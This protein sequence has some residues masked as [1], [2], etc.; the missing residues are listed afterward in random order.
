MIPPEKWHNSGHDEDECAFS[1]LKDS[2]LFRN[3]HLRSYN[4]EMWV[5]LSTVIMSALTRAYVFSLYSRFPPYNAF[6]KIS[7]FLIFSYRITNTAELS[8]SVLF[9]AGV[10]QVFCLQPRCICALHK[11]NHSWLLRLKKSVLFQ[12]EVDCSVSVSPAVFL[13]LWQ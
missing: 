12:A 10:R 9:T 13:T 11:Q 4:N 8:Y 3:S 1:W 6:P 2:S 7:R 5:S